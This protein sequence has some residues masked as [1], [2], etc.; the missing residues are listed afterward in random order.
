MKK[1]IILTLTSIIL[2]VLL[3][4][5]VNADFWACFKKGDKI[6]FCNP[7]TPDR[8]SPSNGYMVCIKEY[9]ETRQCYNQGSPGK[10]NQAGG[11]LNV[12]GNSSIDSEPPVF[13]LNNPLQNGIYNSKSILLDFDLDEKADV[14]YYDNINGRGRWTRVCSDC[15]PGSP[16]YSK[17]RRFNEGIN[18]LTFKAMDVIGNE[19][20]LNLS[21]TIDSKKPRIH[22]TEPRSEYASGLF[23]IQY[24]EENLKEIRIFY[25]N[26]E[27]GFRNSSL[28]NCSSGERKWCPIDVNL[29]DYDGER[30]EYYFIVKDIAR[31]EKKSQIRQNLI[32]DTTFPVLNNPGSFWSYTAGERYVYFVFNI[33]EKNLDK[34]TYI[35][36]SADNPRW[37]TLCSRLKDGICEA[38][39]SFSK[40]S[41]NVDIQITDK[42]GNSIAKNIEFEVDY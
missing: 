33:T 6:N 16:A 24:S 41:H 19:M 30:I 28:N 36:N 23:E 5:S 25:G 8:T 42:A 35:D 14:Y 11:C 17:N 27:T 18:N 10:C 31:N 37:K 13:A 9:N 4:S 15:S 39:K 12:G 38:K 32:V 34:I 3:I 1:Q 2:L 20:L 21:F 7:D 22:K 26:N 40:G 29:K